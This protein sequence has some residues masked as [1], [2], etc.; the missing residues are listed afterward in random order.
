MKKKKVIILLV[1]I[2]LVFLSFPNSKPYIGASIGITPALSEETSIEPAVVEQ[3]QEQETVP[4]I[5]TLETP[6]ENL[7]HIEQFFASDIPLEHVSQNQ[8]AAE[9]SEQELQ[10]LLTDPNV[11][12]IDKDE[13]FTLLLTT[14]V[15]LINASVVHA[16]QNGTQNLTGYGQSV[17]V[18]DSGVNTTHPGI[19]GNIIAQKCFCDVSD[20]GGGGCCADATNEDTMATD[21]NG[22]GT[23]IAGIIAANGTSALGVAPEAGIVSVKVTNA[24]GVAL[25]SDIT[26]GVAWCTSNASI[27]NISVISMSLGGGSY[28]SA[29]DSNYASL[30]A[31]IQAAFDANVTVVVAT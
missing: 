15:P 24:S 6:L 2:L 28:T 12:S 30:S 11:I 20:L 14:T 25:F 7:T 21:D 23:Y 16:R 10:D 3:L 17:C 5:I 4:V 19:S 9:I 22:H 18:I 27:Y 13:L 29:C 1:I 8:Y 31:E 26:E